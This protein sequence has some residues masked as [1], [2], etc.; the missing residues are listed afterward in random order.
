MNIF[1]KKRSNCQHSPFILDLDST[2]EVTN[3]GS[4]YIDAYQDYPFC[5]IWSAQSC[6]FQRSL[7]LVGLVLIQSDTI[8]TQQGEFPV[9]LVRSILQEALIHSS[10]E[11]PDNTV[12]YL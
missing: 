2:K 7:Y 8:W 10:C 6:A 5:S 9:A 4:Q 3:F 1:A 12:F 11:I